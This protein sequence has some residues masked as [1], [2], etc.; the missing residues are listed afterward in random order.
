LETMK[1]AADAKGVAISTAMPDADFKIIGDGARLQQVFWNLLSNAVRFTPA[2]GKIEM[3][4]STENGSAVIRVR[5]S[6]AGIVRDFLPRIFEPFAQQ[7]ETAQRSTGLGLGLAIARRLVELH[8]GM[9]E[10]K[11]DGVGRGSEFTI[12][13]PILEPD[14]AASR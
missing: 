13:L 10:A 6:G 8:G 14:A 1:P 5:D 2:G 12:R 7:D 11:S 9:I 3:I 4:A